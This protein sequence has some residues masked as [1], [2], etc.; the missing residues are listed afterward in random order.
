MN[1]IYRHLAIKKAT[2]GRWVAKPSTR[3]GPESCPTVASTEQNEALGAGRWVI[4]QAAV[5]GRSLLG[6]SALSPLS[7]S[8]LSSLCRFSHQPCGLP[9]RASWAS[10]LPQ[11]WVVDVML[12]RVCL[13]CSS[14]F[15]AGSGYL[16]P[17]PW[18]SCLAPAEFLVS[19]TV[20]VVLGLG[21]HWP[22]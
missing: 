7:F 4:P 15:W 8:L 20:L 22:I 13:P 6:P 1:S 18:M 14:S 19:C 12:S 17:T 21:G 9:V 10:S 11:S 5:L 2:S 3:S 16:N